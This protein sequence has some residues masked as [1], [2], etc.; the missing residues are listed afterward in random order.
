M[1]VLYKTLIGSRLYGLSH[2]LS[3]YDWFVVVEKPGYKVS[4]KAPGE[5]DVSVVDFSTFS[6]GARKGN[7]QY[8]EAMFSQTPLED[9]LWAFRKAYRV[10]VEVWPTY[11]A[12]MLSSAFNRRNLMKHRR[13]ALR[14]ALNFRDIRQ[15]GRFDPHMRPE[16]IYWTT[17]LAE[18]NDQQ[19]I[20]DYAVELAWS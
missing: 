10:G 20:F 7:P 12:T 18:L 11:R 8:L 6:E 2:S 14:L 5:D 3:D 15:Y 16:E 19:A 9:A 13:H 1:N 17:V 4:T